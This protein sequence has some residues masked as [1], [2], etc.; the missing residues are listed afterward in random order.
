MPVSN[1]IWLYLLENVL[2]RSV[3]CNKLH[4]PSEKLH[5]SLFLNNMRLLHLFVFIGLAIPSFAQSDFDGDGLF[6]S[7]EDQIGT[8]NTD[9]DSDDDGISDGAEYHIFL[10]DP[11]MLDSDS[12]GIQDGTELGFTGGMWGN[13]SM[14]VAG[15]DWNIFIPDAD[16]AFTTDPLNPDTDGGG[17]IDGA[18]DLDFNGHFDPNTETDPLDPTD[19][20]TDSDGDGLPDFKELIIGTDP[21]D[22]DS[23]D[24]GISD[25]DEHHNS[26]LDPLNIDIDGDGIQ[27]GTELGIISP[28]SG[29]PADGILGT[30]LA[31]WIA[32]AD[33]STTTGP[34]N[35]DSDSG[36]L[37]DGD[38][39]LNKN[40]AVDSGESDPLDSGDDVEGVYIAPL[41]PGIMTWIEYSGF[42]PDSLVT[43]VYST[44]GP[45]TTIASGLGV[46]FDL[47]KPLT[48]IRAIQCNSIG[49]GVDYYTVPNSV[50]VGRRVWFQGYV[51]SP[52]MPPAVTGVVYRQVE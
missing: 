47:R 52:G 2:T 40:G 27:D 46:V 33:P 39:D 13:P 16:S 32:D 49:Y 48:P 22:R 36:G 41:S 34:G 12:D 21:W 6:D 7:I 8:S 15:T 28:I 25:Y 1:H 31:V 10:T 43:P 18:E 45:G 9:Q 50:P 44:N 14:G 38:E 5:N 23:D 20:I 26:H 4:Y 17:L 35:T 24:D 29:N 51:L 37:G 42:L 30:D 11:T 3:F 19:D